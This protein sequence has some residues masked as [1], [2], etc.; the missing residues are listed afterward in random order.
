MYN[1]CIETNA[2]TNYNT[3]KHPLINK[4]PRFFFKFAPAVKK[5]LNVESTY[6]EYYVSQKFVYS[7]RRKN[8]KQILPALLCF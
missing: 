4:F 7:L 6:V 2:S 3:I 1:K 8:E 5:L